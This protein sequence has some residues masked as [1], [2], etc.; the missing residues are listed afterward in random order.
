M[1]KILN[2]LALV[3]FPFSAMTGPS[4]GSS[5]CAQGSYVPSLSGSSGR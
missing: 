3:E 2:L 5:M 4:K 1:K